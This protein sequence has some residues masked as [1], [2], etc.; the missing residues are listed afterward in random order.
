VIVDADIRLAYS[1][2]WSLTGCWPLLCAAEVREVDAG[3]RLRSLCRRVGAGDIAPLFDRSVYPSLVVIADVLPGGE[4]RWPV[5]L[6][7][8]DGEDPR[9]VVGRLSSSTPIPFVGPDVVHAA[10]SSGCEVEIVSATGLEAVGSEHARPFPLYGG[11]VVREG[12]D[13]VVTIARL[14]KR[15][16]EAGDQRMAAQ[17]RVVD[18]ALGWGVFARLDQRLVPGGKGR[19]STVVERP[20]EWSWPPVAATVPAVVRL[21]LGMLDHLVTEAGSTIIARDTDG[22]AIFSSPEGTEKLML[23]DGSVVRALAYA[24]LDAILARFDVLD[25]F[26]D[27]QPF[28]SVNR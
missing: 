21:W 26:A 6:P 28:W 2:A 19:R 1:A 20:S 12:D 5:E 14:R 16:K 22:A 13:P 10:L 15:A 24:E 11:A 9:V 7:G 3:N 27:G 17:L 25:P 8:S 23:P 4:K 18:S